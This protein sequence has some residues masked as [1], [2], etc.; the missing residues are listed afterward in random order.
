[1]ARI[2]PR[3]FKD[4]LGLVTNFMAINLSE[5]SK[6]TRNVKLRQEENYSASDTGKG[7]GKGI[8]CGSVG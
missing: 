4:P 7:T 2:N 3:D 8:W 5:T 6:M 1:M